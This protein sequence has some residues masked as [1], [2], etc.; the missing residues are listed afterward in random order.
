MELRLHSPAGAD[1]IV[2]QWPLTSGSGNDR[3]DGALDIVETMRWVCEDL[4]DLKLPLKN[5]VLCNYDTK[6]FESMKNLCDRFNK[7]ID[8]MV[9]LEKGT[10]LP[11]QRLNKRPSRGLLRHILQQTY[12][13]AVTEP[14]KLNQYEPFSPEV[15]G[16]TSYELICQMIDQIDVTED[17]VFIDLGSGVGQV[18][19]QMAAATP[20]KICLGVERADVPA[21]YAESMQANFRKWLSWYG[22]R[23]GEYRIVK[24]DFLADEHK[25]NITGATIVFVNNFAFGPT[26]DHQLKERFADLRDGARIVSS[27]SFC[28]LNFRITD[29]NLTDIG[30]I[31][32][33]SE[34]T[35]L[36]GSVSWTGKPV[37][38]YLHVIDRTK[39]E[40]YFNRM[41]NKQGVENENSESVINTASNN[42]RMS[43]RNERAKRDLSRQLDNSPN[44]SEPQNTN[45]D[46]DADDDHSTRPRRQTKMRRKLS[47]KTTIN[48]TPRQPSTR[49]RQRG[50]GGARGIKKT[51]PKKSINITGLDFL[52]NQTLLSTSPQAIGKKPPPAPG[53]V[54]QQLTSL[55]VQALQTN[56]ALVH[57]ELSIPAAPADTPYA[58]QILLDLYRDQFMA[59]LDAMKSPNYKTSVNADIAREKDRNAKLQSRAAQLEKQI[60]VLIDDSVALLKARMTE[61]GI[62]ATSPGDLLA[63]AKEI[64]L[65]HKQLQA[66]AS[67]LQVQVTSIETEQTRLATIRHQELVE[68]F[69]QPGTSTGSSPSHP[70]TQ[71]FLMKEIS[72]SLA[73][74][75][76]LRT[77]VSKLEQE[78]VSVERLNIEKQSMT[79]SKSGSSRKSREGR[80]RSQEWPDVPDVGKIQEKNPELLAQKILETGRQIEAGRLPNRPGPATT[81]SNSGSTRT[82]LPQATLSFPP[83]NAAPPQPVS[84][85]P[86]LAT[87]RG[88]QEP[89]R[90][91]N[92]E[93]R[94][95]SIITSSLNAPDYSHASPAKVALRRHLSQERLP[96]GQQQSHQQPSMPEHS[97]A[98][99]SSIDSKHHSQQQQHQ[100]RPSSRDRLPGSGPGPG[101]GAPSN[102]GLLGTRTIGD[103]VSGEIERT[104][105]ISNQTIINA[106]VD[107][108]VIA[109][110][111]DNAFSPVSRP[112]SAEAET[113]GGLATLAHVASYAPTP[114]NTGSSS[115]NSR[116]SVLYPPQQQ[117]QSQ[118]YT[119]VQLPRADIKPYHESYFADNPS[120]SSS[121]P[122]AT[123]PSIQNS[124]ANPANGDIV[125][126]EGL[127]ATLHAR[128]INQNSN[129]PIK[130]EHSS[131]NNRRYQPYSRYANGPSNNV[132]S[133]SASAVTPQTQPT[134]SLKTEAIVSTVSTSGAPLSPFIE[135]HSNNSTP[136]V[137]E[138]RVT[139]PRQRHG[140]DD[141]EVDWQ[142]QISSGFDRLMAFAS[143]ELDKRRRSTE[144]VNTSPDSGLGSDSVVLG[145]PPIAPSPDEALGPPRTPSPGSPRPASHHHGNHHGASTSHHFKKKFF[146]RDWPPPPASKFRPKGKE[147]DWNNHQ[148]PGAGPDEQS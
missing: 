22:K 55:S 87:S 47:R 105:E 77:Q 58:L 79:A 144:G 65:R 18:V 91:A 80:S 90:V 37:S 85:A 109:G 6:D 72:S 20:C 25:E 42:T 26:V 137:D 63:K 84:S 113:A 131:T 111:P 1:P 112:Q 78:L 70:V 83:A 147:W 88:A 115:T 106:A 141:A 32:H 123:T 107:M 100:Q 21:K 132:S 89:P 92:F 127:A 76:R 119:P 118:R 138:P 102:G 27:K 39:L 62:N 74:R 114:V 139:N 143:T 35:P 73:Q 12:N 53:C 66:K 96:P 99:L 29:R 71:E 75:K 126:L 130:T 140:D 108:S 19:L 15:Y 38:Y 49:G 67:K 124:Q 28:P 95:K 34:M 81:M 64:V 4:P 136:I 9:Q 86:T 8:T 56:S 13:Q 36:K 61:L 43:S 116:S 5:N 122:R 7:A 41:K 93:D 125:P 69:S 121:Q 117:N 51:K 2:Y 40:R 142:D 14:D 128:M 145:P 45:S 135:P 129:N 3:H 48:N 46:S 23:C 104:L 103:L 120:T 17:D 134:M 11:S 16:E 68:K 59:M 60:K 30:T 97:S 101:S 24:G 57:E 94:L 148:W 10:S 50:G 146:H 110:R 44:N 31:M 54:D 98:G 82:R 33:V 133:N 52:H